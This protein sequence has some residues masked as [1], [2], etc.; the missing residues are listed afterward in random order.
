VA[1]RSLSV[2][3]DTEGF[4]Q[5]T[6]Q[7]QRIGK[8]YEVALQRAQEAGKQAAAAVKQALG[9]GDAKGLSEANKQQEAATKASNRAIAASYRELGIKSSESLNLLRAQAV[10]AFEAIKNS[11]TASAR[12]IAI[13]QTALTAKLKEL[14]SQLKGT[15]TSVNQFAASAAGIV[16]LKAGFDAVANVAK[17]TV[18]EFVSLDDGIRAFGVTSQSTEKQ[19]ALVRTEVERL[20]LATSKSPTEIAQAALELARAGFTA[21]ETAKALEGIVRGSEATGESLATVGDIVGKT[22]RQFGLSASESGR[23]A[24]LLVQT[25]NA[26]NTSVSGLGESLK[27]VGTTAATSNQKLEDILA[28]LGLIGNAGLQ[29]GQGGRNLATALEKVS[30][31]SAGA[32]DELIVTSRG[33]KSAGEAVEALGIKFRGADGKLRPLLELLPEIK[34]KLGE[35]KEEDKDVIFKV[36]FG[37]EGGRAIR[38]SLQASGKDIDFLVDKINNAQGVAVDSGQKLNA[39]LGGSFRLLDGSVKTLSAKF[40]EVFAPAVKAATDIAI[41]FTNSIISLPP[42]VQKITATLIALVTAF[43]GATVAMAS[44]SAV[45]GT[46]TAIIGALSVSASALASVLGG[47]LLTAIGLLLSPIGLAVAAVA[48]LSAGL[49]VA[50]QKSESFRNAINFLGEVFVTIGKDIQST[51]NSMSN[52]LSDAGRSFSDFATQAQQSLKSAVE[53]VSNF[54]S[55]IISYIGSVANWVANLDIFKP[56]IESAQRAAQGIKDAFNTDIGKKVT[57]AVSVGLGINTLRKFGSE[58]GRLFGR[59]QQRIDAQSNDA[60]NLAQA[61]STVSGGISAPPEVPTGFGVKPKTTSSATTTAKFSDGRKPK[62][63][64]PQNEAERLTQDAIQKRITVIDRWVS[65]ARAGVEEEAAQNR[66]ELEKKII[67]AKEDQR[68][69]LEDELKLYSLEI[70]ATLK[71]LGLTAELAKAGDTATILQAQKRKLGQQ[72]I[73]QMQEAKFLQ[74]KIGREIDSALA[75]KEREV[76]LLQESI[77]LYESERQEKQNAAIAELRGSVDSVT[78]NVLSSNAPEPLRRLNE[79]KAQ[80]EA[81]LVRLIELLDQAQRLGDIQSVI[82]VQTTI[83]SLSNSRERMLQIQVEE[84]QQ[85]AK[86][87]ELSGDELKIYQDVSNLQ[88]EFDNKRL[89]IQTLIFQAIQ[90]GNQ[91]ALKALEDLVIKTDELQ[92]KQTEQAQNQFEFINQL[93]TTVQESA[94]SATEQA[95]SDL[96]TLS[97]GLGDIFSNFATSILKSINQFA[98]QAATKYIFKSLGLGFADGGFVSGAGTSRSDSIPAWLSNGEFVMNAA[99]TKYWGVGFLDSLNSLRSPQISFAGNSPVS[100]GGTSRST[101]VV[102]NVTTPDANSF[103]RSESQIGRDAGEQLRRSVQRNG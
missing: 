41:L 83:E 47:A 81:D 64:N 31:A 85:Q 32:T 18:I 68:R 14:E 78:T 17:S 11:G 84:L 93:S 42:P 99:S 98:A 7:I 23:V 1:T 24:D 63:V 50:Y 19:L 38:A 26:S 53:N 15:G 57:Y 94:A 20:G 21:E 30:L 96:F 8:S 34:A 80:Y 72:E 44:F 56:F 27:F 49:V 101:N 29:G 77:K 86:L 35:L 16:A 97:K 37:T 79:Q 75:N 69:I 87:N 33:A 9:T 36:L 102:V 90:E 95:L 65:V 48:A 92:R 54:G 76:S 82:R 58:V 2:K 5:A 10:S 39:G 70:D 103:R 40:G 59:T 45:S 73:S 91:E 66:F 6:A 60:N 71:Q 100:S 62:T 12:D 28:V 22:I 52:A 13:A 74:E 4:A 51:L 67:S 25:A 46:A 43:A 55:S 61:A 89:Q 88:K 3:F